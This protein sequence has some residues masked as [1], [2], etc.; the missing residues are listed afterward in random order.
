MRNCLFCKIVKG[1]EPASV[2]YSDDKVMAFMA[3]CPVNL[4]HVLVIPKKTVPSV[5]KFTTH[6]LYFFI[7]IFL[8]S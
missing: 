4:G 6:I 5:H 8:I 1:T 2:V 3:I 7:P